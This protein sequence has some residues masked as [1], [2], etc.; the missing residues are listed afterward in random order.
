VKTLDN[1]TLP[2]ADPEMVTEFQHQLMDLSRALN[3]ARRTVNELEDKVEYYLAAVKVLKDPAAK[4]IQADIY[5]MQ[6]SLEAVQRKLSG[7]PIKRDLDMDQRPS[8]GDRINEVVYGN[9]GTMSTPTETQRR[10]SE[11]GR[12]RLKP[13]LKQIET[14]SNQTARRIEERL[15]EHNAPWTPGRLPDLD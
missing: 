6:D 8:I 12:D 4:D 11:I 9:L 13:V 10:L 1:L 7:D 15:D 3:G 2:P 5:Q 14:L